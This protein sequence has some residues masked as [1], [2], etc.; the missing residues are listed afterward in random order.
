MTDSLTVLSQAELLALALDAS[1]RQ[2]SGHALAYLKEAAGRADATA[3]V[4]FLLASEYAQLGMTTEALTHMESAVA[5]DPS[6]PIARFQLGMLHVTMGNAMA[7]RVAWAAMEGSE[8][9]FL[10]AFARGMLSL[11]DD[12]FD[13]AKALLLTGIELNSFN[14]PLNLDMRKV[15]EAIDALPGRIKVAPAEDA[16]EVAQPPGSLV[17][18]A[19][20]PSEQTDELEPSHLFISAYTHRGKPH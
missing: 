7:A 4:L 17:A 11:L 20:V 6:F 10:G 12:Q 8:T 2:D 16:P 14:E 15:V 13:E 5:L 18:S 9:G 1:R 3:Q 19:E